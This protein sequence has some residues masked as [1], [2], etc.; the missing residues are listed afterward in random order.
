MGR[1]H[2]RLVLPEFWPYTIAAQPT[3]TIEGQKKKGLLGTTRESSKY[4][5]ENG[6]D[7]L[8]DTVYVGSYEE[9][10]SLLSDRSPIKRMERQYEKK[11]KRSGDNS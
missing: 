8:I 4:N 3:T 9:Y 6:G 7:Y 10:C 11:K 2:C 1:T 5:L